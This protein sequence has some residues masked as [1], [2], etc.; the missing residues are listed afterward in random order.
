MI[1]YDFNDTV[2]CF[3]FA[4]MY[5]LELSLNDSKTSLLD[6]S[7][8]SDEANTDRPLK[9]FIKEFI[10]NSFNKLPQ[11]KLETQLNLNLSS[12]KENFHY[13]Y[14]SNISIT[15][16]FL[17]D[18]LSIEHKE[19][20]AENKSSVYTN[21]DLFFKISDGTNT[22]Y[23]SIELKSTKNNAIPGSSI[24]QIDADEWVIF[25][26]H[27]K[28]SIELTTG[29]YIHSINSKLQFPDRSPRPQV[30][31]NELTSWNNTNRISNDNLLVYSINSDDEK[32]KYDLISDWQYYLAD[33]WIEVLFSSSIKNNEPWYNNNLRKFI[34]KFLEKYELLSEDEK[35]NLKA[36]INSLIK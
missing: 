2:N 24:Q 32:L 29:Q 16:V 4:Y 3:M 22:T 26:K 6:V 9:V 8:Q 18:E 5:E 13:K 33:R 7:F 20:I 31:F 17:P 10:E 11:S 30:A 14:F 19:Q 1:F 25:V 12:Y 28:N 15:K 21:P 35:G 23:R 36:T 27:N 34:I